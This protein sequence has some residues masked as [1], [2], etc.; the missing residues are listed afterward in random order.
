MNSVINILAKNPDGGDCKTRLGRLLTKDERIFLSK[1]MLKITCAEVS[2]INIDKF[3]HFYPDTSG[4]FAKSLSS[5]Y[6]IKMLNQSH[7]FLSKKIYMA[8]EFQKNKF[9]KRVLIGS[10]I[11]TISK[12][13]IYECISYLD[14][15]DLVIGP[16]KD[17]GF[18]LVGVKKQAHEF[19][20]NMNLNEILVDDI[21]HICRAKRIKYMML[22]VLKDIDTP[23]DLLNL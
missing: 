19:F 15:C 17:S 18:Y 6:G 12:N 10:D 8:L 11:P 22:R 1:E 3:L 14:Y 9:E 4:D 2:N 7:G 21:I 5:S 16:S 20:M 23:S 13:E